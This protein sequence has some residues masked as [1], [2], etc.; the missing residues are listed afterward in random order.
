MEKSHFLTAFGHIFLQAKNFHENT[1]STVTGAWNTI[2][3]H[4]VK[5]S[6]ASI[7]KVAAAYALYFFGGKAS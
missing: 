6:I 5:S 4:H 1:V 7:T 2:R 3:S